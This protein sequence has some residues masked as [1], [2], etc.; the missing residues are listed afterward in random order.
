M[1]A[2]KL[3]YI[4]LQNEN[5]IEKILEDLGCEHIKFNISSG[6]NYLTCSNPDGNNKQAI[7]VYLNDGL[8]THNYTRSLEGSDLFSLI[9]YY[10]D[11]NLGQ[12]IRYVC[13]LLNIEDKP[14][15]EGEKSESLD[16][17]KS[18][19]KNMKEEVVEKELPE[20]P[21][22]ELNEYRL[23]PHALFT[24][25]NISPLTQMIFNIRFDYLYNSIIIPVVDEYNR[26][27]GLK[28]RRVSP[29]KDESKYVY[30]KQCE[31]SHILYGLNHTKKHI[32]NSDCVY[33]VESEK[34]VLQLYSANIKNAVGI[35]SHSISRVQAK[36]L[37]KL[38]KPIVIAFDSDIKIDKQFLD[39]LDSLFPKNI[40]LGIMVDRKGLMKEKD[41]PSDNIEVFRELEKSIIWRR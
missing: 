36:K 2:K 8:V 28:A 11:C 14:I 7:V 40:R 35:G 39:K 9:Q 38:R 32:M 4:I 31:R 22:E 12:A 6:D 10:R 37:I 19:K 17:M 21:M 18:I 3:K 27:V 33:V 5:N 34:G 23:I 30:V 13:R 25:D 41:S 16:W 29:K 20:I 24:R 26:T 15:K 1:D